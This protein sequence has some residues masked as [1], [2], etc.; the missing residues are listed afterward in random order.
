MEI[1]RTYLRR[2]DG[3]E[4]L[5]QEASVDE[6]YF[7]LSSA[8][9]YEGA[10]EIARAIKN[11]IKVKENLTATIGIGPNKLIAKIASDVQKPDGLTVVREEDAEK[12]LEPMSIRTIP[13]IGP[14]TEERFKALRIATI[15]DAKKISITELYQMMGKRGPELYERL[16]G[17]DNSPLVE[18]YELKSISEQETFERDIPA[19]DVKFLRERMRGIALSVYKRFAE[20]DFKSFRTIGITVRFADFTTKTRAATLKASDVRLETI[21]FQVYRLLMPFLDLRENPERKSFRLLGVKI[22]KLE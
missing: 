14:K 12:F 8:G 15:K 19:T 18:E 7:D 13:G 9:S 5:V 16:R 20:S 6:A 22:E 1:L 2:A 4:A 21:D 10:A 11:E 17:R 3:H